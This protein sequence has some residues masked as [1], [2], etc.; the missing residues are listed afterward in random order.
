MK[1]CYIYINDLY[2]Q[3][4]GIYMTDCRSLPEDDVLTGMRSKPRLPFQKITVLIFRRKKEN[5]SRVSPANKEFVFFCRQ[6]AAVPVF[7]F[8][9]HHVSGKSLPSV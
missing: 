7:I 2:Y 4:F 5:L 9:S 1:V 3:V 8:L 6:Y